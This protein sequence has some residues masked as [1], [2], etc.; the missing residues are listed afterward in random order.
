MEKLKK[1]V[2]TPLKLETWIDI[3]IIYHITEFLNLTEFQQNVVSYLMQAREIPKEYL[4]I[5]TFY[6]TQKDNLT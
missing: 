5:V 4:L 3:L 1:S 2:K 6:Q